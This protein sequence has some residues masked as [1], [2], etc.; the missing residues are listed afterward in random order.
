M[1]DVWSV[2]KP[3]PV[4]QN[5]T[6]EFQEKKLFQFLAIDKF[7]FDIKWTISHFLP[8]IA[9]PCVEMAILY[10]DFN[11]F[12]YITGKCSY[13]IFQLHVMRCWRMKNSPYDIILIPTCAVLFSNTANKNFIGMSYFDQLSIHQEL[14]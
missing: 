5:S 2:Y 9:F 8:K 4:I 14:A 11:A 7:G 3:C 10:Y 1:L 12:L 6:K 13:W